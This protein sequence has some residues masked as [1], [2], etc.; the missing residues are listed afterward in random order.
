MNKINLTNTGIIALILFA[1]FSRIIPHI[2]NFTPIGA[3]ALFGGAYLTNKS[4]AF[5]IP[6]L[7]LWFSDLII[8]NFIFSYYT[9]FI[10]FYPGF[11]WQYLSFVIITF[12]GYFILKKINY[13]N[14]FFTTI[15]SSLI[16]F[17]ITNFGVW[18]SG[19]MYP[20]NIDGL[21]MCYIAALPF[22]KGTILGF[23]F[24]SSF[25]FGAFESFKRITLTVK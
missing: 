1:S 2:P 9:D 6:V 3:M 10:F 20:K 13:K 24:Y 17:L 7:S 18:I 12:I 15:V 16:F 14:V 25:L 11:L 22:Y 23:I 19:Y 4:H 8:N 5:L 21:I